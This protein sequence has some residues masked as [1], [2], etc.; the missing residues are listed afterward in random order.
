[1]SGLCFEIFSLQFTFSI[2]PN[3][4]FDGAL[5]AKKHLLS[6]PV[7][8]EFFSIN[9]T[10]LVPQPVSTIEEISVVWTIITP[11]HLKDLVLYCGELY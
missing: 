11:F 10:V 4:T 9:E 3:E 6:P 1:M 5:E 7:K 8:K 2:S